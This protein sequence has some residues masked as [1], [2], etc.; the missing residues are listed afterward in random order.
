MNEVQRSL[1]GVDYPMSGKDLAELAKRNGAEQELVDALA[2]ISREVPS[3]MVV[4]EELKDS[5]G[6]RTPGPHKSEEHSY[7]DV[8]GPAF[9]VNE[10]R[11]TSRAR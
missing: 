1:K 10:D 5:L 8:E 2:G 3:P 6:G 9:Q 11:S 4:M 7:K